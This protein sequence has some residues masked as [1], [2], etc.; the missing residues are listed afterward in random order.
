[1][2]E[3]KKDKWVTFF[4]TLAVIVV[5]GNLN[6]DIFSLSPKD[7]YTF[8]LPDGLVSYSANHLSDME[9]MG[10]KLGDQNTQYSYG[11]E[12]KNNTSTSTYPYILIQE[13][14]G[15]PG[16]MM[17]LKDSFRTAS[18]SDFTGTVNE[19]GKQH[20]N[21]VTNPE[22]SD[23]PTYDD[24]KHSATIHYSL[25]IVGVGPVLGETVVFLGRKQST[26][27]NYYVRASDFD[28][29]HG[30]FKNLVDSFSWKSGYEYNEEI[31]GGEKFDTRS[32]VFAGIQGG[33]IGILVAGLYRYL[34]KIKKK[35]TTNEGNLSNLL[36]ETEESKEI[37]KE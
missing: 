21:T 36:V 13:H 32:Y 3:T 17:E 31:A 11:Y 26:A 16:T 23:V 33:I 14:P 28:K 25:N 22:Y 20:P 29:Y 4:I 10:R 34:K 24:N 15:N 19:I 9:A 18:S 8:V 30:L 5:F 6:I 37:D 35:V 7:R 27:F 12:L 2:E 1:M